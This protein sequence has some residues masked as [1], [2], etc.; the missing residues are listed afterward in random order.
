MKRQD[1]RHFLASPVRDALSLLN[2]F[3][4]ETINLELKMGHTDEEPYVRGQS[5]DY[6]CKVQMDSDWMGHG[7]IAVVLAIFYFLLRVSGS[8]SH[9]IQ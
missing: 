3:R 8:C 7:E 4:Y 5:H 6:Y 9:V 2:S 1:R